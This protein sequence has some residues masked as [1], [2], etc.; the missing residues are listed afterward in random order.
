MSETVKSIFLDNTTAES[1]NIVDHD[2]TKDWQSIYGTRNP[3]ITNPGLVAYWRFFDDNVT[4]LTTNDA[5]GNSH[6]ITWTDEPDLSSETPFKNKNTTIAFNGTSD[7]GTITN[8]SDNSLSFGDGTEDSEFSISFWAKPDFSDS[9]K[10]YYNIINKVSSLDKEYAVY[11]YNGDGDSDATITLK[12][13]DESETPPNGWERRHIIEDMGIVGENWYNITFT[14]KGSTGTNPEIAEGIKIYVNGEEKSSYYY[15]YNDYVAMEQTTAD[16]T[17]GGWAGAGQYFKGNLSEVAIW[18]RELT[19]VEAKA[20]H[21]VKFGAISNSYTSYS[22]RLALRDK[23]NQR[24][25]YP[26][27]KRVGDKDRS[28]AFNVQ[29]NDENTVLFDENVA[30]YLPVGLQSSDTKL[31]EIDKKIEI[32]S[33]RVSRSLAG[34]SFNIVTDSEDISAY[35][36]ELDKT[37]DTDFYNEGTNRDIYPGFSSPLNSKTSFTFDI[38][39]TEEQYVFR[40]TGFL[41]PNNGYTGDTFGGED[42]TGFCY[43]SFE[44]GTWDEKGRPYYGAPDSDADN[45]KFFGPNTFPS[46]FT[47]GN[48][49]FAKHGNPSANK[50]SGEIAYSSLKDLGYDK[51]GMPT[52]SNF[53]PWAEQYHATNEQSLKVNDFL[54]SPFLLEKIRIS[55]PVYAR[56]IIDGVGSPGDR[57]RDMKN[58]MAFLYLQ[59]RTKEYETDSSEDAKKSERIIIASASLC[60]YN[61]NVLTWADRSVEV[62]DFA[63]IH[64][65]NFVHAFDIINDGTVEIGEFEDTID[66]E[67]TPSVSNGGQSVMAIPRL[68]INSADPYNDSV[69]ETV[70]VDSNSRNY[71]SFWPGGSSIERFSVKDTDGI[72]L[73]AEY[74][75]GTLSDLKSTYYITPAPFDNFDYDNS[76]K[77]KFQKLQL[78]K[79]NTRHLKNYGTK[80]TNVTP[81]LDDS[82][83][84]YR[85]TQPYYVETF[86]HKTPFVL[87]PGD[88]LVLG[89]E[90]CVGDRIKTGAGSDVDSDIVTIADEANHNTITSINL[91]LDSYHSLSGSLLKIKT[92]PASMTL[93]GSLIKENKEHH[94]T[95]NQDLT[96]NSVHEAIYGPH[97]L[98]Q[99]EIEPISMY[100]GTFSDEY[101][102]GSMFSGMNDTL[103]IHSDEGLDINLTDTRFVSK[104]VTAGDVSDDW[105][106][107]RFNT[108]VDEKERYYDT[109][110]PDV[111]EYFK[112][113]AEHNIKSERWEDKTVLYDDI[114]DDNALDTLTESEPFWETIRNFPFESTNVRNEPNYLFYALTETNEH[115]PDPSKNVWYDLFSD[116]KTVK[117]LSFMEG[118][119][120][121]QGYG[122]TV[123]GSVGSYDS[124]D[125]TGQTGGCLG[126]K[127]GVRNITPITTTAHFRNGSYGQFRD[128][129]EQRQFGR[130][131]KTVNFTPS[132]RQPLTGKPTK[133]SK[134]GI[135]SSKQ[136]EIT[137]GPLIIKF[138]EQNSSKIMDP[139]VYSYT[140]SNLNQHATSSLPYFDTWFDS[141]GSPQTNPR[142]SDVVGRNRDNIEDIIA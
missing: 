84:L 40:Q 22:P 14:S 109:L 113:S 97:V 137:Q 45:L 87:L 132:F 36:D 106:L 126:F 68:D 9:S 48:S 51:I 74:S 108:F 46:Q 82:V 10:T 125:S 81:E 27:V 104:T 43:Y 29:F 11:F 33:G 38:T 124:Y 37:Q 111:F 136:T 13:Y 26:T 131:Y 115:E 107:T 117:K 129:L 42:K 128:M 32:P 119:T 120:N 1:V 80:K 110:L 55:L 114:N 98:D 71:F 54:S 56:Q 39:A 90:Q 19:A 25:Q 64:E 88:E 60:F 118:Y 116:T 75:G 69:A 76:F 123:L 67:F 53:A 7:V 96:S 21:D 4:P 142:S 94:D 12:C 49:F 8:P 20:L 66:L 134:S 89:I 3:N 50:A 133:F 35:N 15:Y 44:N 121:I 73:G 140:S 85:V 31:R 101:V 141:Q 47:G 58:Y 70:V 86:S 23:D 92:D 2:L 122:L 16:I 100:A 65:P 79:P 5:S 30:T 91:G 105:S 28:G 41:A 17:I 18:N 138:V 63:P 83:N 61:P 112:A 78:T 59:R 72:E 95:M 24:G 52:I 103:E 6:D 62:I 130:F 102:S 93:Y 139:A 57:T 135:K 127:H 34:E 77:Q 99:F